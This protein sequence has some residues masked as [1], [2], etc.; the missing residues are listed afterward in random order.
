MVYGWAHL[1]F[2]MVSLDPSTSIHTN[3]EMHFL[4]I[5][6]SAIFAKK[7][8]NSSK[9]VHVYTIE[10]FENSRFSYATLYCKINVMKTVF[11]CAHFVVNI[12]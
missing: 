9:T 3:G 1:A 5:N 8:T 2:M 11:L 7:L 10:E 6:V 4:I 12:S